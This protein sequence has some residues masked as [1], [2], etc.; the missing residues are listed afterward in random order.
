M[1]IIAGIVIGGLWGAFNARRR[2]GTR[3]DIAQYTA[4]G[5]IIG[6]I[7]GMFAT[8]GLERIL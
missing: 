3:L 4:V 2:S 7:I 1:I 8:V 6:A 5:A